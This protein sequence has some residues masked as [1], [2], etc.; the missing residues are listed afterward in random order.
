[1]AKVQGGFFTVEKT[2]EEWEDKSVNQYENIRSYWDDSG[3]I[4]F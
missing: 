3:Q 4:W 1:M 2:L